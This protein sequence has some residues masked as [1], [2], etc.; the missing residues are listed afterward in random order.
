[1]LQLSDTEGPLRGET[2]PVERNLWV[3]R[4]HPPSGDQMITAVAFSLQKME[5]VP[6]EPVPEN[7][8]NNLQPYVI[9]L[10]KKD[11]FVG[12]LTSSGKAQEELPLRF[13]ACWS[14]K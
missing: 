14:M 11:G 7:I 3:T 5:G 9:T 8:A 4:H 6:D 13:E 1:V 10:Q 12:E 2:H